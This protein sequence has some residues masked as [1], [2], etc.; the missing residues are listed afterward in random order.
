[1]SVDQVTRF[2]LKPASVAFVAGA[3][4]LAYR[5]GAKAIVFG[6]EYPLPLVVAGASFIA[7]EVAEFFSSIVNVDIP[8]LGLLSHPAHTAVNVGVLSGGVAAVENFI[9]PGLVGDLG[10][11]E[12]IGVSALAEVTGT[13]LANEWLKPMWQNASN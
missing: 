11:A 3:A 7:S 10:A 2:G 6:A 8:Q 9:S 5:P 1:M 4:A 13:F 12:V